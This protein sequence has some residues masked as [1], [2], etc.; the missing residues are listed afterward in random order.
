MPGFPWLG[1]AEYERQLKSALSC[2]KAKSAVAKPRVRK[3][4]RVSFT[5]GKEPRRRIAPQALAC[6]KA[7]VRELMQRTRG[8]SLAQIMA[9]LPWLLPDTLGVART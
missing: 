6:F 8:R 9:R 5:S 1:C 7:R 3:F 2:N 4:L